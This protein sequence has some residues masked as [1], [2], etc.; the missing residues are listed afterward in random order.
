MQKRLK[1][2]HRH[3][4]PLKVLNYLRT[5]TRP[6]TS[7]KIMSA[8][9]ETNQRVHAALTR[10]REKGYVVAEPKKNGTTKFVYAVNPAIA[11]KVKATKVKAT[12]SV[13]QVASAVA[14]PV[15]HFSEIN[16]KISDD[17]QAQVTIAGNLQNLLPFLA[18]LK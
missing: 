2:M 17:G 11:T 5:V 13:S 12:K 14:K 10:L 6:T 8:T 15:K 18:A 9:K 7:L 4:T 3:S 1:G 16:I